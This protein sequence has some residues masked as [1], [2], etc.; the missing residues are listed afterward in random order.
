MAHVITDT[1]TKDNLCVDSCP[2]DAIHPTKDE[3]AWET[4]TQLYIN[5][6][7]CMD[8]GCV[9]CRVPDGLDLRCRGTACGQGRCSGKERGILRPVARESI[10][11]SVISACL[12]AASNC[13]KDTIH[14]S[15]L[16]RDESD[17][18]FC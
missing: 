4:V 14:P 12:C 7:E 3:P 15:A 11:T 18:H 6:A 1:C 13:A 5:P 9:R 16:R 17:S 10:L 2:S 8:C